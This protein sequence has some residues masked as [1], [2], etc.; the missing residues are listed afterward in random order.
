MPFP[1]DCKKNYLK[2][3]PLIPGVR[4]CRYELAG[5]EKSILDILMVVPIFLSMMEKSLQ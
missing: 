4:Q 2:I 5:V 3:L 1:A